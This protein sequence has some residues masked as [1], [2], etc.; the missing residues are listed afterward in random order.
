VEP[1]S[2]PW[3]PRHGNGRHSRRRD[4]FL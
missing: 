3:D 4:L 1:A 2:R